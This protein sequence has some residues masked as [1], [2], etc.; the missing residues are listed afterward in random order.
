MEKSY[1]QSVHTQLST[2]LESTADLLWLNNVTDN[3]LRDIWLVMLSD[4]VVDERL[5]GV[6]TELMS[7]GMLNRN[8]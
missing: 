7:R 3:K 5:H 2:D 8:S 6:Q 1:P 4:G